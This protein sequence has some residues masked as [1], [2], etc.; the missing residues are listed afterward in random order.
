M[1]GVSPAQTMPSIYHKINLHFRLYKIFFSVKQP[2]PR[3]GRWSILSNLYY[4]HVDSKELLACFSM[5]LN[6]AFYSTSANTVR[7]KVAR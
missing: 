7:V 5:I 3:K 6:E 4:T 2:G 1:I